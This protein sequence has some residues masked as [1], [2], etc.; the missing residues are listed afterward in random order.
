MC[1]RSLGGPQPICRCCYSGCS[2]D[3]PAVHHNTLQHIYCRFLYFY[4]SI[5]FLS[6]FWKCAPSS[7]VTLMEEHRILPILISMWC[8]PLASLPSRPLV[9]PCSRPLCDQ[10]DL[11]LLS[12]VSLE[13]SLVRAPA[14]SKNEV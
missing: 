10:S 7:C 13:L 6:N 11:F 4:I 8:P 9:R 5:D 14:S 1:L 3:F 12:L 2:E